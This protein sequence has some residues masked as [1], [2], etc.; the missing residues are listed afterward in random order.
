[1]SWFSRQD[2]TAEEEGGA[3]C[4]TSCL[5]TGCRQLESSVSN[6][7]ECACTHTQSR[8]GEFDEEEGEYDG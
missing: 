4:R 2:A 8:A 6:K 3:A 5:R 7:D 1:M